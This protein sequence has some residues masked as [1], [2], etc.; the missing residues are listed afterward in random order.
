M[1]DAN[2]LKEIHRQHK[3]VSNM[4]IDELQKLYEQTLVTD[5]AARARILSRMKQSKRDLARSK[6]I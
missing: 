4:V 2:H 3:R 6:K 5:R 1:N